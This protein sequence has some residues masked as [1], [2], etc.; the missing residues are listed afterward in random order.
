MIEKLQEFLLN[1]LA[2][3]LKFFLDPLH[4]IL[5]AVPEGLWRFLICGYLI[6]GAG[7]VLFLDRKQAMEGSPSDS[8]WFD[9]RRWVAALL[10]PCLLIYLIF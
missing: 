3:V 5:N 10:A 7:W 9:L 4:R 6:V 8:P 2:P 1:H